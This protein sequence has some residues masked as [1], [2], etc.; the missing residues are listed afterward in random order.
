MENY[1]LFV[2]DEKSLEY[3]IKYG[4]VGTGSTNDNFN[5]GIWKDIERLK[6]GDKI[7][8]YTQSIKCFYGVFEVSS[9]PFFENSNPPY[10]QNPNELYIV[11]N[12]RNSNGEPVLLRYRALIKPYKVFQFGISEFDL[13]DILPKETKDVL[14]SIIYRKLLGGRGNSPLFPIEY[15]KIILKLN[16]INNNGFLVGEAL[17]FENKQIILS[18][19]S[20]LYT[21]STNR[22]VNTVQK[23]LDNDYSEHDI[24][25]LLLEKTPSFIFGVNIKWI[26]NEVY[27]GAAMQAID[28]MSINE[29]DSNKTFNIIEVK[30]VVI[31]HRI[32]NQISKY[33]EW[34]KGRFD[35]NNPIQSLQPII[36]GLAST[37]TQKI[38]RRNEI[39]NFNQANH[40]KPIIYFEYY[41]SNSDIIFNQIDLTL[42]NFPIINSF[43]INNL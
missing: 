27:S 38:K 26:G 42:D 22:N 24:H 2:V 10:L 43:T 18:E 13:I 15:E 34:V 14:W 20:H 37:Q 6:I 40:S 21:G 16:E 8:F 4:F 9:N 33:I 31:P 3:H 30:K 28:L 29:I 39:V 5:I 25:A 11:N 41:T 23:I 36:I 7:I 12:K 1:H 19:N 35:I 17:E 32:T